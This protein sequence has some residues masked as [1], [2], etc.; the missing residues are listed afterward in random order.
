MLWGAVEL[1]RVKT[2]LILVQIFV[3]SSLPL[4]AL[5]RCHLHP[6]LG[7]LY[8]RHLADCQKWSAQDGEDAAAGVTLKFDPYK[9]YYT[10]RPSVSHGLGGDD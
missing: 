10:V 4:A 3:V 9:N 5:T 6:H 2:T 7:T 1:C 8:A